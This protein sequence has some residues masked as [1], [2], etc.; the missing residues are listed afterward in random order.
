[1]FFSSVA[2][3]LA[4]RKFSLLRLPTQVNNLAMFG[5]PLLV[6]A[7]I[8]I[9]TKQN[10][11]ISLLQGLIVFGVAFF[12]SYL[13]NVFSLLSIES[14]PNPGYSLIISKSYVVFTTI[15]AVLLFHA[16]LS[17]QKVI[18][19]ILI[20]GFSA[21]IMINPNA[22]KKASK[23]IWLPLALA[24]FFCFGLLSLTSKYLFSHGINIFVFL[25]YAHIIATS[26]IIGEIKINKIPLNIIKNNLWIFLLIGIFSTSFYL[27]M[28]EAIKVAPNVGYVNAI[29][30][31]SI[32]LVTVFSTIL[33]KD[34]FSIKKF[35]GVVGV[36]LGLFV[37]LV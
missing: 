21:L 26:C 4:V 7:A 17:I 29:N 30:A 31:S 25:T 15:V 12:F 6:Y 33:F 27:F 37:L 28:F 35:I 3:Y 2:L 19:I 20:V 18:A 24:A 32:S 8:G 11:S 16:Q 23:N 1:M 13:G 34:E 14:A 9:T 10:Y 22:V 5:V 36:A